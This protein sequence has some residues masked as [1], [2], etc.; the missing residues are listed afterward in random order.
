MYGLSSV[1]FWSK[2]L[3]VNNYFHLTPILF[4]LSVVFVQPLT[5]FRLLLRIY[6]WSPITRIL[7]IWVAQ[8][9][10]LRYCLNFA[11]LSK[12]SKCVTKW[13]ATSYPLLFIDVFLFNWRRLATGF[14]QFSISCRPLIDTIRL[15]LNFSKEFQFRM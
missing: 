10:Y 2:K 9:G 4:F 5:S 3:K 6:S 1:F 13:F 7:K 11:P 14:L 8:S 12:A 15:K